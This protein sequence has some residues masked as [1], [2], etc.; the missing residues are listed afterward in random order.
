M[1]EN[2]D[3]EALWREVAALK[4]QQSKRGGGKVAAI[5]IA[6][7]AVLAIVVWGM[8]STAADVNCDAAV[9]AKDIERYC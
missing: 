9:N 5:V 3:V 7:I 2:P 4:A 8:V 6:V 1:S